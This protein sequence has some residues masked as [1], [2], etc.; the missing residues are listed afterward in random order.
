MMA[1]KP[2]HSY[3]IYAEPLQQIRLL[4]QSGSSLI[5]WPEAVSKAIDLGA[6]I[7]KEVMRQNVFEWNRPC[8]PKFLATQ[9]YSKCY[10]A[11]A[12]LD[13]ELWQL[14]YLSDEDRATLRKQYDEWPRFV[15]QCRFRAD[16]FEKFMWLEQDQRELLGIGDDF[17]LFI[18]LF[19]THYDWYLE[20]INWALEPE[21]HL[22][23]TAPSFLAQFV[24]HVV[25]YS[26]YIPKGESMINFT[27]NAAASCINGGVYTDADF[28]SGVFS[29]S[30]FYE[31]WQADAYGST[32]KDTDRDYQLEGQPQFQ[33][34]MFRLIAATWD[35]FF[36]Q[37]GDGYEHPFT[38]HKNYSSL[39]DLY[40]YTD[41]GPASPFHLVE[42]HRDLL[43]I[44][45]L[46]R[47]L[48]R[49]L[50]EPF[51]SI[52]DEYDF[53]KEIPDDWCK[54][55]EGAGYASCYQWNKALIAWAPLTT[56]CEEG[57][58][59]EPF[60]QWLQIACKQVQEKIDKGHFF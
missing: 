31:G 30:W 26:E 33:E 52:Q 54:L 59:F 25:Q 21:T 29:L 50:P 23:K 34:S 46:I 12:R 14:D 9:E 36:D 49:N 35:S 7:A 2:V 58:N 51:N 55:L 16:M 42:L 1:N 32:Q 15:A 57:E 39:S 24:R 45:S 11:L 8:V 53:L 38:I 3:Q 5:N 20:G 13:H 19:N 43:G 47:M 17:L 48:S 28:R 40:G 27:L 10:L 4:E 41:G 56:D 18:A 44:D 60:G 22:V 37:I 6:S